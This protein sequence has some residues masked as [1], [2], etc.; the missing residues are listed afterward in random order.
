MLKL[1]KA[2]YKMY[3]E[4]IE[5]GLRKLQLPENLIQFIKE[6]TFHNILS[7][8]INNKS[9]LIETER[10]VKQGCPI[11]LI[12]YTISFEMALREARIEIGNKDEKIIL[13]W[14]CYGDDTY[15]I[16][17]NRRA[18]RLLCKTVEECCKEYGLSLNASKIQMIATSTFLDGVKIDR[19]KLK[20]QKSGNTLEK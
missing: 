17:P 3:R 12:L 8:E 16:V 18:A 2:F 10:G 19:V 14:M 13:R 7:F 1:H 9:F 5:Y 11:L 15:L 20:A 4:E 6:L